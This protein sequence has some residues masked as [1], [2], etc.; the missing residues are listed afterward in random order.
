MNTT[1]N[2][3]PPVL[4]WMVGAYRPR[5]PYPVLRTKGE[6]GSAQSTQARVCRSFVDPNECPIRGAPA[7]ER[8]LMIAAENG[9]VCAFDNLSHR[10]R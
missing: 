7:S 5:G 9:W 3:W 4:G 10:V 2:H 6:M 8:D 1:D